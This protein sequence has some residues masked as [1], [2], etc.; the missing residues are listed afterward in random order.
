M[1]NILVNIKA[2]VYV[3]DLLIEGKDQEKHNKNLGEILSMLHEVGVHL[4]KSK[5]QLNKKHVLFLGYNI[6]DGKFSLDSYV[7]LQQT[8]LLVVSSKSE[9][10][11]ILE[12]FNLCRATY[13]GLATALHPLQ[14]ALSATKLPKGV[15]F[16]TM[17]REVWKYVL[18]NQLKVS[19]KKDC[20]FFSIKVDW[21]R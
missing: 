21:S 11:K 8:R 9:I 14:L 19:L 6:W 13:L 3:N 20:K 16:K 15:E 1:C 5:T 18:A 17:V 2:V 7:A 12:I 10:R 4:N